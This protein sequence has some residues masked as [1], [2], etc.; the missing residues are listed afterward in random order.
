M[1]TEVGK[2]QFNVM[3]ASFVEYLFPHVSQYAKDLNSIQQICTLHSNNSMT[4][5]INSGLIFKTNLNYIMF[6]VHSIMFL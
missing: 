6:S 1:V 3:V 4:F 2:I 5:S